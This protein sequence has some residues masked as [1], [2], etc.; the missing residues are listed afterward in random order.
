MFTELFC[1]WTWSER[2]TRVKGA[3][4]IIYEYCF[5][6]CQLTAS[7]L[8]HKAENHCTIA[9]AF[10]GRHNDTRLTSGI[11]REYHNSVGQPTRHITQCDFHCLIIFSCEKKLLHNIYILRC[12][13][14]R[15]VSD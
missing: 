14:T 7:V 1:S 6:L 13:L 3:L 2:Q 5:S 10:R 9:E 12:V 4:F 8:I 15:D 11:H